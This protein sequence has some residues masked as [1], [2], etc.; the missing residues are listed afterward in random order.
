[1]IP[2]SATTRGPHPLDQRDQPLAAGAELVG[3]EL[4]GAGGGA[5]HDVGDADAARGQ[6]L[7]VRVGHAGRRVDRPLDDPGLEQRRVEP[8]DRVREVGLRGGGPEAGVDADEEQPQRP[9]RV[10]AAG[11]GP[12]RRGRTR[13]R[14]VVKRGTRAACRNPASGRYRPMAMRRL[15]GSVLPSAPAGRRARAGV[16]R[17][18]CRPVRRRVHADGDRDARRRADQRRRRTR[19]AT[20]STSSSSRRSPRPAAG[21]AMIAG[22]RTADRR[23]RP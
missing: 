2:A 14:P 4:V 19:P 12:R 6:V 9:V 17:R 10:A 8:V 5:A 18:G 16:R 20:R 1:M 3:G 21:G 15:L 11:R 7:A 22:R 13:A 23:R